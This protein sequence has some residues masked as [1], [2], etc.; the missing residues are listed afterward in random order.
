[1]NTKIV[2]QSKRTTYGAFD[3][4][5]RYISEKYIIKKAKANINIYPQLAVFSFD[6]I[7]YQILLDGRYEG[8]ELDV[9]ANTLSRYAPA[10]FF[11]GVVLD[12]GANIG[13]HSL[14]F[15]RFFRRVWSFEPNPRTFDLLSLNTSTA[16]NIEVFRIGLSNSVGPR[17]INFKLGN[18]GGASVNVDGNDE[19]VTSIEVEFS[20]V[21][22]ILENL[23]TDV[24]SLLKI[25]TEGHEYEV[26]TGAQE[27]IRKYR[28]IV[29]F[30]QHIVDFETGST[31]TIEFLRSNQYSR[32]GFTT[33][34]LY[35]FFGELGTN[36][37]LIRFILKI[38][39]GQRV[40][41]LLTKNIKPA[42]YPFLVAFPD[43]F[44]FEPAEKS[45]LVK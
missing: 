9:L 43:E 19:R 20:T 7:G 40:S 2:F 30:E 14:F 8:Q 3:K 26:V 39:F 6:Y 33:K 23:S 41:M 11:S 31:K 22:K 1:V 17:M 4:L 29:V 16:R 36:N 28:P 12:I 38:I 21:D 10:K 13:N 5:R 24:I 35:P 27:T 42:F 34:N 44:L 45:Q 37:I 15:S 18:F 25:D 32:F